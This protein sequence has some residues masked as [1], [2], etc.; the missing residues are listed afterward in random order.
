AA[1]ADARAL[2]VGV[3]LTGIGVLGKLVTG[4]TPR[5]FDGNRML[6]GVAMIPRGEVGLIFAQVAF[7]SGAIAGGEFGAIM[8]MVVATTL[9]TPPWLN[10][11]VRAP[12]AARADSGL[13]PGLSDLVAGVRRTVR[14]ATRPVQRD[15]LKDA[16]G[17]G[18]R[19]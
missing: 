10:A 1:L 14:R 13:M 6:I 12:A 19:K 15:S 9:I 16:E 4:W 3:A 2:Q 8:M 18:R 5:P 17:D 11:I 7:G